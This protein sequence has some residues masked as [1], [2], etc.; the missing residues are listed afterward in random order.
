MKSVIIRGTGSYLPK[1]VLTNKDLEKMMDTTDDWI[2]Q[3]TG[4]RQRHVAAADEQTS[5]L[6]TYACQ[7]ALDQAGLKAQ[8]LDFII[9]A[10]TSADQ[11]FPAA[12]V[13]VQYALGMTQ[14]FAFD[15][16]AA[17]SGF[18][19]ALSVGTSL[20]KSGQAKRGIVV[21]ADTY[22]R[23]L[24]W[25]DRSTAIL[26]GDG[27]GAV[28]LE[29]SDTPDTGVLGCYLHSD[30]Q[31]NDILYVNGGPSSSEH[32]GKIKME[33]AAVFKQAVTKLSESLEE[34]LEKE[35]VSAADVDWFVP[36]QANERIINATAER[37]SF[38]ADKI[39]KTVG[40]HANTSAAS[41]PLA[42]DWGVRNHKIKPG[43]LVLVDA[44]GAGL[45]WGS[46]LIR[47][48]S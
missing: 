41:I 22:S 17:C 13:K 20:I 11:T 37:L 46:A 43:Q 34:V 3:R 24:D 21:G 10:T 44:M 28:V 29:A 15:M 16:Q 31:F 14:G 12:A 42:L 6:A 40:Q 8:D 27:A 36:H 38:P 4:I 18:V 25:T 32:V 48:Y 5:H 7:A 33:G 39:I 35:K 19:Y 26:F 2:F 45:S 9:C 1:K 23:I 30:G 47:W